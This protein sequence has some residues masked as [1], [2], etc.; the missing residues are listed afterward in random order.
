M[1]IG[2]TGWGSLDSAIDAY[3]EQNYQGV[4]SAGLPVG[5]YFYSVA[6]TEAEAIAEA[7][8]ALNILNSRHLDYPIYFDTEEQNRTP[9]SQS[10]IGKTQ[11]T[12]VT[13]AF[14]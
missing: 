9:N 10:S 6:I 2:Y 13:K 3:F 12:K 7:K 4:I 8:F 5:V 11:L 1:R 14:L